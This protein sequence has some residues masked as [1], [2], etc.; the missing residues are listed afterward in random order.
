FFFVAAIFHHF[1]LFRAYAVCP[2][3]YSQINSPDFLKSYS[4]I[5]QTASAA[6]SRVQTLRRYIKKPWEITD[7]EYRLAV[8]KATEYR[9]FCPATVPEKAIVPTSLPET[10]YDIKYYSCD[11]RRNRPPIKRTVLKKADVEKMM[12]EKTFDTSDFPRPYLTAKVVE[13]DNAIGG[14]Y[15]K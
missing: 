6:K 3:S 7:P 2:F 9:V 8:P 11:Q 5:F 10:V 1:L 4:S 14:G 13:D 12:K 15:Q